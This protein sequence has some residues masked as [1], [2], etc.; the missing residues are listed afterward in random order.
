MHSLLDEDNQI[1]DEDIVRDRELVESARCSDLYKHI[2]HKAGNEK[3]QN[4]VLVKTL[5]DLDS[6]DL[7]E[8][9][10]YDV[11]EE[12]ECEINNPEEPSLPQRGDRRARKL[13]GYLRDYDLDV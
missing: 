3:E 7:N 1:T 5:S 11:D 4:R 2:S 12:E 13:P 6:S 10:L 9:F 8:T